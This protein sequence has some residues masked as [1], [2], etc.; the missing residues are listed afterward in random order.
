MLGPWL[1]ASVAAWGTGASLD[2][3]APRLATDPAVRELWAHHERMAASPGRFRALCEM[4]FANDTRHMLP[5]V[6]VP[7]LVVH[8][9]D[10]RLVRVEHGRYLAAHIPGAQL[11]EL[12]DADH[13]TTGKA[14]EVALQ[15]IEQF[16]SDEPVT[17]P[18]ERVLATVAFVDITR[19][20]ETAARLGDHR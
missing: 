12:S 7:T 6:G 4:W 13:V 17:V 15:A 1:D 18:A 11:L 5:R 10:D 8:S 16:V 14:T 19:S 20:T 2:L 9:T 3:F